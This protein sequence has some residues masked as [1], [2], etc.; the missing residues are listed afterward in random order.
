M[1][2]Q[3]FTIHII[4]GVH[5]FPRVFALL[6]NK[7]EETYYRLYT[8]IKSFIGYDPN[9]ISSDLEKG[10]LNAIC[11]VFTE[12]HMRASYFHSGQAIYL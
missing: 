9:T 11:R 2:Y 10:S 12:S 5:C 3:L 7:T 8:M 4:I 6:P 1:F